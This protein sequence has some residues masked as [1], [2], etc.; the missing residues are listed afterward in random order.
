MSVFE[1]TVTT[2]S[3]AERQ[4]ERDLLAVSID[5]KDVSVVVDH[6]EVTKDVALYNLRANGG[7]LA[8]T[9][10]CLVRS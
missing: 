9:L 8:K 6:F 5:A 3:E 7:D 1:K 10:Q 2:E 4:R